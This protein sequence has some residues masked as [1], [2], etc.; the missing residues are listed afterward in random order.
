MESKH[1]PGPW[2]AVED[3]TDSWRVGSDTHGGICVLHDPMAVEL[4][5]VAELEANARL[6]AAAPML[7]DELAWLVA[8]CA[9][10]CSR[11]HMAPST[12]SRARAALKTAGV[13]P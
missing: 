9:H 1:T 8:E 4:G 3:G 13:A 7:A 11:G 5:T 2:L 12:L 6:I 10:L